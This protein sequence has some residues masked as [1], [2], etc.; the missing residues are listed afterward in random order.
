MKCPHCGEEKSLSQMLSGNNIGAEQ[1]SDLREFAPMCPQNSP[2]QK[3]PK[4]GG[5]YF[6]SRLPKDSK[7]NGEEFSS[8]EQGWLSFEEALQAMK[9]I[10]SPTEE[11]MLTLYIL[12]VWAYNDI[13]RCC[14]WGEGEAPT[15]SQKNEF[16]ALVTGILQDKRILQ[17]MKDIK[18]MIFAAELNREIG[19]FEEAI[20]ILSQYNSEEDLIEYEV[21]T[22][23]KVRRWWGGYTTKYGSEKRY[24]KGCREYIVKAILA[25]AQEKDSDIFLLSQ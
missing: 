5:Y 6:L 8:F 1:W 17:N 15:E 11:E 12:A 10:E 25:K 7:R 20:S 2:V 24:K 9:E 23:T 13:V 21:L 19:N 16:L 4:C 22:S 14:R 3:C 18:N